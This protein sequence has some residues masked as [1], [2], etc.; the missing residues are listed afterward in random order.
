MERSSRG[1]V[2][3]PAAPQLL[4]E[5]L[6]TGLVR[7]TDWDALPAWGRQRLSG[8]SDSNRLLDQ[9]LPQN[10]LTGYQAGRIRAHKP[11]WLILGKYRVL[12][13]LGA[14]CLGVVFKAENVETRELA[15]VKVLVPTRN[16]TSALVRLLAERQ[17]VAQVR[18]PNL[19]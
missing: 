4:Q 9:L 7:K 8:A 1:I 16:G 11:Q 18:H 12:D 6:T 10:L 14:G 2:V 5:L 3:Q 19:V 13:R 17:A 15:A